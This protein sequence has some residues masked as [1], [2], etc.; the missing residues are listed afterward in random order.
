MRIKPIILSLCTAAL[1]VAPAPLAAQ[2]PQPDTTTAKNK[3]AQQ[4]LIC[5]DLE[6]TGTRFKDRV[7]LTKEE[8][9]EVEKLR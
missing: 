1:A 6:M 9:K 7:C 8:W 5:R 2:T 3:Q 4:K